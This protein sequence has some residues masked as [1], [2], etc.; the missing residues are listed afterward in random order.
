MLSALASKVRSIE[1]TRKPSE[2]STIRCAGLESLPCRYKGEVI[3]TLMPNITFLNPDDPIKPST[4][5][6]VSVSC[7]VAVANGEAGLWASAVGNAMW[8]NVSCVCRRF[9]GG[10]FPPMSAN[11]DALFGWHRKRQKAEQPP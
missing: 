2:L 1:I 3:E 7:R 5:P 11:E 6:K 9:T 4:L 8:R 10:S